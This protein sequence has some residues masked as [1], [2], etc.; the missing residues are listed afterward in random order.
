MGGHGWGEVSR[1]ELIEAVRVA[2]DAGLTFFD[3][4]DT[5]GLGEGE[6]TLA[7]ALGSRRGEAQIATKF[8]VRVEG[9]RTSYDN[10]PVWIRHTLE[11]SLRRL[12][13]DYVDLYQI[14]YRD[15]ATPMDDVVSVLLD[16]QAEGKIRQLGLSNLS[17]SGA[18]ELESSAHRFV[19]FQNE[20]SLANRSHESEVLEFSRHW[21]LSPLTW[22]SLGQGILT[23]KYDSSVSFASDDRRSR[24]VYTNFHGSKLEHNM[25]I[26][27]VLR[28]IA[29]ELGRSIPAVAIRWILDY[30]PGSVAI[31]GIK[32]SQ[33]LRLNLDALGWVLPP[34]VIGRLA[35]VSMLGGRL[36]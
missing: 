21:G 27:G 9:G 15:N 28:E 32:N 25:R 7:E 34:E 30:I 6:A 19:S 12:N 10:S 14:H 26:V 1:S 23:G 24:S 22:G 20:F 33:Q 36:T 3:T 35:R 29:E 5:Y 11:Q 18:G 2:L 31:V 8:G 16:L 13:T 17:D 4:A